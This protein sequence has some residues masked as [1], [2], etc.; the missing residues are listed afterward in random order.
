MKMP[1]GR[2]FAGW[3]RAQLC[4]LLAARGQGEIL[5]TVY[6]E[7]SERTQNDSEGFRMTAKA[8]E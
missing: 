6:P 5:R 4:D 3:R 2:F 7:R 1:G 8:S